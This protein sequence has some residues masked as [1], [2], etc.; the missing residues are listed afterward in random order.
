MCEVIFALLK[1]ELWIHKVKLHGNLIFCTEVVIFTVLV[2]DVIALNLAMLHMPNY[3]HCY[4][5]KLYI[6]LYSYINLYS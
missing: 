2:T 4:E 3:R 5:L 6:D 1:Y